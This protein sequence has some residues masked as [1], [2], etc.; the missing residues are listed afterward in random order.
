[1]TL[2]L[3]S[4]EELSGIVAKV[5]PDAVQL[6]QLSGKEFYDAVVPLEKIEALIIRTR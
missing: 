1:M 2:K 4:A 6:S 5:G 3:S